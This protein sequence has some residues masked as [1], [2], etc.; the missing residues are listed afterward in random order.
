MNKVLSNDSLVM[1]QRGKGCVIVDTAT[2]EVT[3]YD[4]YM[5]PLRFSYWSSA[6]EDEKNKARRILANI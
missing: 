4:D 6:T 3:Q 2:K 1:I 5:V